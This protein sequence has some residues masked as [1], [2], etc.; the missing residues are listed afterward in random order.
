MWP[1]VTGR[2]WEVETGDGWKVLD[3]LTASLLERARTA[4]EAHVSFSLDGR[5]FDVDFARMLQVIAQ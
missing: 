2:L 4:G 3:P 1:A 5:D